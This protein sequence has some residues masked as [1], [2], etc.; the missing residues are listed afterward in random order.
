[1]SKEYEVLQ[2]KIGDFQDNHGNTWCDM[3][4]QGVSEP[5]R[6][7]VKD[8]TKIKDG[9]KLYGEIKKQTSKA[10][11]DYL[12][13]YR[14][15]R[16]DDSQQGFG[17]RTGGAKPAWQPRDDSAIRAQWAI[18]QAVTIHMTHAP[19][20][21]FTRSDEIEKT[22]KEL[23]SMV[24]RVKGSVVTGSTNP[25]ETKEFSTMDDGEFAS[26]MAKNLDEGTPINLEEIPF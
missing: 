19:S 9:D 4:L 25:G 22:A 5:V 18:G 16:P 20:K 6:I 3:T 13:F 8:P 1:M 23:F 11:K 7:V 24:D 10:G 17:N 26:L 14:E 12:R 15:T 2:F 21:G